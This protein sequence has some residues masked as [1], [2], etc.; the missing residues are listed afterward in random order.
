MM[1]K[2][3][4]NVVLAVIFVL[5]VL[6]LGAHLV[7][8][9]WLEQWI[10][11]PAGCEYKVQRKSPNEHVDNCKRCKE[12]IWACIGETHLVRCEV[13]GDDYYDCPPDNQ[14]RKRSQADQH[15]EG[16]CSRYPQDLPVGALNSPRRKTEKKEPE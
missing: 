5:V 9:L 12:F 6:M 4:Q 13:C 2:L 7:Y 1:S 14:G 3:S 15:G 16:I 8:S 10:D 11:C